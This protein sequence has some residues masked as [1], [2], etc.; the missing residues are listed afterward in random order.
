MQHISSYSKKSVMSESINSILI[1]DDNPMNLLLTSKILESAGYLTKTAQSGQE[2]LNMVSEEL[3]SLIL[4]DISMPDMDGYEVCELLKANEKWKNIPVIF[5]TANIQTEDVVKGF[6]TGGVDYIT[7]PFKSEE[8]FVR[9]NT[10]LELA[11][12]RRKIVEMNYN[13]DKLYS[14]IAHDIRSPLSG[15]LQTLDAIDQGFIAPT[16]NDFTEIIN[17]LKE[18]TKETHTLLNSLLQ[19]TKIQT[20][21]MSLQ[22]TLIELHFLL[23]SCVQLLQAI[24]DVKQIKINVQDG[25]FYAMCDE[26][27]MHTVFRNL[28]SNAVKF[29]NPGGVVNIGFVDLDSSVKV[30][31]ADNGIGMSLDVIQRIF[32]ND[33][34]FSSSG[35]GNEQGTGL[36]L[37]L[38]KDFVKKNNARIDVNSQPGT[39]TTFTVEIPKI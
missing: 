27:S 28:I 15:I 16:D 14:I 18:R 12:S 19:W 30:S 9:V 6:K 8:L 26:M 7:K 25:V 2:G 35:T 11:E 38:V 32:I 23:K 33:E 5:L 29:T 3:P 10:H 24:A 22:P 13:R 4:L 20:D 39:G 34:H 31:I 1:I 37:M 17:H 36:G 21:G